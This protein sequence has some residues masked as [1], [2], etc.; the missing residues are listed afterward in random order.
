[1]G[2]SLRA[3][4]SWQV[5]TAASA[6]I[7]LP[8]HVAG[9]MLI[10]RAGGKVYG[11]TFSVNNGW[12]AVAPPFP[13]PGGVGG[14]AGSGDTMCQA[15]YK[16]AASSS[17]A[18]PTLTVTG[19]NT[20]TMACALAYQKDAGQTWRTPVGA[21]G[22]DPGGTKT[23]VDVE[24]Q[25]HVEVFGTDMLDFFYVV[26]DNTTCSLPSVSQTGIVFDT[27]IEAPASHVETT[28]GNDGAADGGSR[29]ALSG[30]SSA[31]AVVFGQLSTSEF[32]TYHSGWVTR[33][34]VDG[35]DRTLWPFPVAFQLLVPG[36]VIDKFLT[37]SPVVISLVPTTPANLQYD[38]V[39]KPDPVEIS[40]VPTIPYVAYAG[41]NDARVT[42][43]GA[44]VAYQADAEA[45]IT[46]AGA[47]V[48]YQADGEARTTLVGLEVAYQADAEARTTLVGADVAY[49]EAPRPRQGWATFIE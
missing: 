12:T 39:L 47:D 2:I 48:A 1:M 3:A 29:L 40:L 18:N 31:A 30:A 20:P 16:I 9:D 6:V 44:D 41:R 14:G 36:G 19:T 26:T 24:I 25:T 32:G 33:L 22:Y 49:V 27:V 8:T 42:L 34:R 37:P 4:G 43:V 21:G 15:W 38:R 28:S 45:R 5:F 13:S 7:T 46:L 17:E 11:K 23:T 10:I 35:G